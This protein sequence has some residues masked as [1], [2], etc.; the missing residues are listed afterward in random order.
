M[1]GARASTAFRRVAGNLWS[2]SRS[3]AADE[4]AEN[5]AVCEWGRVV[6]W[7]RPRRALLFWQIGS[8]FVYGLG[9]RNDPLA[10]EFKSLVVTAGVALSGLGGGSSGHCRTVLRYPVS[11]AHRNRLPECRTVRVHVR[12]RP[13]W[14]RAYNI[15]LQYAFSAAAVGAGG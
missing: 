5:G 3:R 1:N 14:G 11:L 4:T 7:D 15:S 8:D 6:E 13:V 2:S 12:R 9:I 10:S